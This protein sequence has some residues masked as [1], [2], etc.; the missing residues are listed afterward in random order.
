MKASFPPGLTPLLIISSWMTYRILGLVFLPN[1]EAFGGNIM[2]SAWIIPL[3]QDALIGL[4]APVI[5]YLIATRPN[6]L[7]YSVA[8]A[9][10][11]WGIADFIIGLVVEVYYPPLA[12][13]FGP[14]VPDAMLSIWLYGNLALEIFALYLLMTP[15]IRDYFKDADGQAPLRIKSTPLSGAWIGVI[16]ASGLMGVFFPQIAIGMD[17]MFEMLGFAPS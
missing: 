7:S 4:T 5:V 10:L 17:M 9:W 13:P 16:I 15:R 14:H 8:A 3:G 1:L 11:W 6:M 2:P 12:G